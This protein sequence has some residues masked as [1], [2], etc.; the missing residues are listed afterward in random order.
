MT[1]EKKQPQSKELSAEFSLWLEKLQQE[2]WQLELIISGLALLGVWYS[3]SL[4]IE[5]DYYLQVNGTGEL[6]KYIKT[7]IPI[8]WFGWAIFMLNLLF[9][10]IIRGLWIGAIGLRYVSGG[11]DFESLKYSE[12]FTEYYKRKVISFDHYIEKLEKISSVIFSYTFLLFFMF[13]SVAIAGL[14]F[15]SMINI[16]E[17]IIGERSKFF[18]FIIGTF[19]LI[20]LLFGAIVFIDFMTLGQLKKV[21]ERAVSVPYLYIYRFFSFISLSFLFRPLLLNFIDNKFTR[22]LFYIS[23]PYSLILIF[24]VNNGYFES[25]AFMPRFDSSTVNRVVSFD[26]SINWKFYDDERIK[27]YNSFTDGSFGFRK[28]KISY[29]SLSNYFIEDEIAT[30]FLEYRVVDNKYFSEFETTIA[31]YESTGFKATFLNRSKR[32]PEI[33]ALEDKQVRENNYMRS[34]LYGRK[35]KAN[36]QEEFSHKE[37]YYRGYN[38]EDYNQLHDEIWERYQDE[39]LVTMDNKSRIVKEKFLE[40]HDIKIDSIPLN[41]SLDCQFYTHPNLRERGLLCNFDTKFLTKGNH[42]LTLNRQIFRKQELDSVAT[43]KFRIPFKKM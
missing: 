27:Y 8:M 13:F 1:K 7:I 17:L 35:I 3:R 18:E 40:L 19:V 14:F 15:I 34:I 26:N 12:V 20:I 42:I 2:S 5:V 24:I 4:L 41:D 36:L 22:K 37:A 21:K 11:I 32:D 6:F 25:H 10:I 23:I 9:H 16:L 39:I 38:I 28:S 29:L 43:Y 30:L 31:P 33:K